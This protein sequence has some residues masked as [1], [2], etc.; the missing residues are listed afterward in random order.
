M[1]KSP[2]AAWSFLLNPA[3]QRAIGARYVDTLRG[4]VPIGFFQ[5]WHASAQKDYPWSLGTAQ[6]D[7]VLFAEQW[8]RPNRQLLP[9][10]ICYHLCAQPPKLGENWDGHRSQPRMT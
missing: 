3:N 8:P 5:L 4:Y 2:Q 10:A 6:H 7:D 9:S 1:Q